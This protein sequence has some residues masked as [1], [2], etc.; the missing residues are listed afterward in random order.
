MTYPPTRYDGDGGEV[1]A[2]IR[3]H[4]ARPESEQA[5]G[6]AVHYLAT[7]RSTSRR[8]RTSGPACS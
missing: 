6:G 8:S 2:R 7:G 5:S 4:D 1:S 3:R